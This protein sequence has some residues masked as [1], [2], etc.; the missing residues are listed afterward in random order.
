MRVSM[1]FGLGLVLFAYGSAPRAMAQPQC[2]IDGSPAEWGINSSGTFVVGAGG[3][4]MIS[5]PIGGQ[6]RSSKVLQKPSRGSIRQ[7]D[8][9][10][11]VYKTKFG[12]RGRDAFAIQITGSG[13]TS[14]GTSTVSLIAVVK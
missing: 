4:C 7:I 10:T 2:Q 6:M 14:A 5:I 9:S 11:Y 3:S 13:P 1:M 8:M 12:F